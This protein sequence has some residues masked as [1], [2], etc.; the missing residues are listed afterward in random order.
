M[1]L[2]DFDYSYPEEL[3]A[4]YPPEQR[5]DSRLMH[6]NR[7]NGEIHHSHFKHF[8]DFLNAGDVLVLNNTQVIPA[9]LVTKT[10]GGGRQECLLLRELEPHRWECLLS[11]SG[12]IKKGDVLSFGEKLS[13][14]VLD[15]AGQDTRQVLVKSQNPFRE[16]LDELGE[17]PLPPYIKR[18]EEKTLDRARYQTVFS[19]EE[20]SAAA[21]TAG[22]HFTEEILLTLR[23]KGVR[24]HFLTLHVGIGTFLPI[25]TD[26][27]DDHRMHGEFYQIPIETALAVNEAKKNGRQ[28]SVVGTTS[29]RALESAT[30][31]TGILQAGSGYTEIFIRP[32]YQFKIV[33]R[34]LTN[35]HQPKSTLLVLVSTLAGKELIS[36]AYTEA[37]R[38][39]YRLFSYGDC[40][41]IT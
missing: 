9:R 37:V 41:W 3:V 14:T 4:H 13:L 27:I 8:G 26:S 22:L 34:L 21:P 31:P 40:M 30:L 15:D 28:V 5:G 2:S 18:A 35:F 32:P 24:I 19:G 12:R 20:G 7:A 17:V 11:R 33:D 25:R 39:K 29:V 10:P 1:K 23:A 16:I 6:V 36:R 38:E